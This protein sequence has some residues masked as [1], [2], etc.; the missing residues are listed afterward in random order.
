MSAITTE[1]VAENT[2]TPGIPSFLELEITQF[3]QLKCTHCY[4][5]SGPHGGHG[6]MTAT[7]WERLID[8]AAA[9]GV[10][11]VQ[12]IGGEPTLD[13]DL[14]RLMRYA[15]LAGVKADVYTNLVHVTPDLWDLFSLPGVSIGFSWYSADPDKHAEIT[16]SRASHARSKANIRE[17]LRR[18][19][20]LRAGIVEV[21]E[22]QDINAAMA[23]LR[24]LGVTDMQADRARAIGRAS[25]GKP[26]DISELCGRCGQGRAAIGMDGQVTPCVLG[27]FLVAGN[28]R[29]TPLGEIFA[30]D[31]WREILTMVPERGTC[32]ACTPSD[33]GDCD[34]S[35]RP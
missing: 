32:V 31:R 2:S 33:S 34:P 26:P 16:G 12:F 9:L 14:P 20:P 1:P 24:A 35:R 19:I 30:G 28:V 29:D 6:A 27:R 13:A 25:Q 23:E 21:V 5:E 15:L 4:S 18:G 17:A 7:D 8:Q 22:N 10:E 11:T 3:C